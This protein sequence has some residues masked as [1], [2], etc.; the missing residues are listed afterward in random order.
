MYPYGND[1]KFGT[2]IY[3]CPNNRYAND[4]VSALYEIIYLHRTNSNNTNIPIQRN[5]DMAYLFMCPQVSNN[6]ATKL[7]SNINISHIDGLKF[8]TLIYTCSNNRYII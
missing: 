6:K 4:K 1:R 8:G 7:L 5:K 3:S 2:L